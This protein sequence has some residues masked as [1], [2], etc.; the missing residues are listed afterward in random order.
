MM[1]IMIPG[2][3]KKDYERVRKALIKNGV[4]FKHTPRAY[5]SQIPAYIFEFTERDRRKGLN[6]ISK[7]QKSWMV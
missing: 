1:K 6:I 5:H 2:G 4:K 7:I 3:N